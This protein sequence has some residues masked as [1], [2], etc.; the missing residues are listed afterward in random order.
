MDEKRDRAPLELLNRPERMNVIR[1]DGDLEEMHNSPEQAIVGLFEEK[2]S[3]SKDRT[4]LVIVG[5][6]KSGL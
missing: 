3:S 6:T 2:V 5:I 1:A 4:T